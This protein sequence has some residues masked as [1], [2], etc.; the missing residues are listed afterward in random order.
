MGLELPHPITQDGLYRRTYILR[1]QCRA[2][3]LYLSVLQRLAYSLPQSSTMPPC[4]YEVCTFKPSTS[5]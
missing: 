3:P 4:R 2:F 1:L 5:E